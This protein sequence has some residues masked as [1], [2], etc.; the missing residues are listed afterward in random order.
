MA[1]IS[2]STADNKATLTVH[3]DL[4]FDSNREFR[5]TYQK[6]P[7]NLPVIVDLSQ[8]GYIDSA[9]LGMLLRL[10]EHTSAGGA[11]AVSLTGANGTIRSIL[12]VANFG[13]L[14]RIT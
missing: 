2:L 10:R 13:R 7:E 4:T 3:G 12:E 6:I 5:E 14:F 1:R 11:A 8:A 9:G